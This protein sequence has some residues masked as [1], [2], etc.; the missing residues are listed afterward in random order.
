VLV[1]V[2]PFGFPDGMAAGKRARLLGQALANAGAT[3]DVLCTL[4]GEPQGSLRNPHAKGEVGPLRFDYVTGRT[5][6]AERF[7]VRRLV[8]L[9][10]FC[11]LL[12]RLSAA[13]RVAEPLVAYS[14]VSPQVRT[15][16]WAATVLALKMMRIPCVLEL[17][18]PPWSYGMTPASRFN[19]PLWVSQVS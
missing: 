18:E 13:K 17:N 2:R 6:R 19:S 8:D 16:Y 7:I 10:G 5:H 4:A 15:P 12:H 11:T 3:V 14:M 9:R 1:I